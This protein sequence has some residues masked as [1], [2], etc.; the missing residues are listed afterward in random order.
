MLYVTTRNNRDTFPAP[1]VLREDRSPDGG[2]YVPFRVP[3]FSDE[4]LKR[5]QKLPFDQR[6]ADILNFLFQ[7]GLTR[8]D[9]SFCIG[10]SPI[11][12]MPLR[13]RIVI[14]EFWHNPDWSF[15][16][17]EQN[18]S[19]LL[20]KEVQLPGSWLRIAVRIA[21]LAAVLPEIPDYDGAVPDISVVSGD[22]LW[23]I[24]IWYARA[25]G[26]PV[27]NLILCC[28]ENRN[29]WDLIC[30]GQLRTDSVSIP[31]QVPEADI[32]VPP[33]LER[34]IY[35]CG[36]LEETE[37]YLDCC[38]EGVSYYADDRM[39]NE[40]QKGNYVSVVSSSRIRDIIPGVL[41]THR[42]LLSPDTALSYAGLQDYRAKK[43]SFRPA[44]VISGKSPL[45]S[46]EQISGIL[47][48]P[49]EELKEIL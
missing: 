15:D 26:F 4:E 8:W 39:L 37:R 45:C 33:E 38:R 28:N 36:G 35:A 16:R 6:I 10:R 1:R 49:E 13:H 20:C 2:F 5:L 44:L 17:L 43:G 11:K 21:L 30:H 34:L 3:V 48:I 14:G 41:G 9:V 42:Y 27:G 29:L 47:G 25:W 46:A 23:P 19:R 18:L 32:P 24:S 31:S 12:L 7:T 22:F 40:L